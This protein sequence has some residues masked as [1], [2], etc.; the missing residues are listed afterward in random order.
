MC[1]TPIMSQQRILELPIH[2]LQTNQWTSHPL[3]LD[4]L[5]R[6][7]ILRLAERMCTAPV[8]MNDK[9]GMVPLPLDAIRRVGIVIPMR[10]P[11]QNLGLAVLRPQAHVLPV[12]R[13]ALERRCGTRLVFFK[14]VAVEIE[15]PAVVG[16]LFAHVD[17][18]GV[19]AVGLLAGGGALVDFFTATLVIAAEREAWIEVAVR[20]DGGGVV[21]R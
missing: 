5:G 6:F 4:V 18:A 12:V 9:L 2:P 16:A 21:A 14:V 1:A 11:S 10:R 15:A 20:E 8:P 7:V 3:S 19:E 13:V 17:V